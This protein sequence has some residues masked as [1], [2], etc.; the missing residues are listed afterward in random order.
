LKSA[1]ALAEVPQERRFEMRLEDLVT[2]SRETTFNSYMKFLQLP[3]D[4]AVRKYFNEEVSPDRLHQGR[5]KSEVENPNKF[6]SKYMKILAQLE[7]QGVA[8]KVLL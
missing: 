2:I 7:R 4:V 5:W 3:E 1:R 6:N 8:V